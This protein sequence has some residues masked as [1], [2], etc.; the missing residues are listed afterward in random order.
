M[1]LEQPVIRISVRN[2]VEFI[3]RA[4]DIDNRIASTDKDTMQLG[5]RI[6]RKIQKRKGSN[7]HAEVPLKIAIEEDKYQLVIEGRAD[8]IL[9][10]SATEEITFAD[11]FNHRT[12]PIDCKVTID[13][14]KGMYMKLDL[15]EDAI[16]VHRAQAMCYAYI[17]ALQHDLS[18]ISVQMTYCNLDTEDI[19][20]FHYD[21]TFEE[22]ADWFEKLIDEY[23]KWADF[24]FA[25]KKL[26]QASIKPLQFPFPY[27]DGQRELVAG[28]YR[29]IKRKKNL[30]IQAPTGAG[31]T[32]S[33]VFP[34][35]K[36]VG[37]DLADKIFYLTAKTITGT[38]AREAFELLRK[39][40]YQAK[41]LTITAKEKLCLCEEME[42]NPINCPYAKGHYDRVN[43]AVFS[44]LQK[45]D[46]I[47]RE[48]ILE[49]AKEYNVCPFEM[50]L[51]TATWVDDIICDY[52][53]V[54]DPNVYLKR[55][56]GEGTSGE[57]IFL[58]DEAHNLVDRGREMYS[59]HVD[60]ADV[61]EAKRLAGDYSKGLVRALEKVNRQLRTLEKECTE[62]EILPNPG[63]VSLGMLQVMGE[64]D[65]LLEELHGKELPEQLLE[66]Y[67]C[68]RDFL[69]I[70]E[71][72]DENYVVYTEMG[73]GGKVILRLFCVNPAANIH[74]CLE[75]GKSAV[76][77]SAT[78]LP[79]DYYRALL[80]TRKD[81]YGIYVTSPFRQENRCIL[82]GRDVSSRYTRRGYEEYHRIASY[83][84]RTVWTRKGN[85][86]VFFPSY[87]FME[88]VLEVYENEFSAEWV[89]CISQTSGMNEREKEEFL[90][91]FSAS[92][93]TL[94]GFCVMG[95]IFSEGIDLM[96]EKLIGAIIIGTGLPQIGTEREILRQY[97]DKKGV[98]GFDYA[99]RYPGMNK[100]LQSAG[101][102]IRTQ[103]DTGIILLLDERFAGKDYRN[104][105]PAEWSDR[106]NCT[107][108]TVEEQ[109]GSFWNR[110][111][112]K[113]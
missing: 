38:V 62:Y 26:R 60:R 71:L 44:L 59:A 43:D 7:Y 82:T 29:T 94:V 46:V 39:N 61:L 57:Y 53:Y 88:D 97:Y 15:L 110:I 81:D 19:R 104:L 52:N 9:I 12:M 103:E 41:V 83:I 107:L 8:G 50:C 69:N 101:R 47:T 21:Y 106:G 4:G 95:G 72:L 96:G 6:H 40:G 91:E 55:F 76:F 42:C 30:F 56:F 70:D 90:E 32:I 102:V 79:M 11:N 87:K 34:A 93:G 31:K 64:M 18:A 13:E 49:Q 108:N 75:K 58:I 89:R 86:M 74:R 78:L 10:E 5:S 80:S 85:Y 24:Q 111:R 37:E 113:N 65:K 3:L 1:D 27:R 105:F 35:V 2:L 51:D 92:E 84:A 66:F 67:F 17:Y 45:E 14:I 68:V 16:G 25:W 112:E 54:F 23:K 77:F 20:Y 100:V 63:A 109:L 28:V 22:L 98:N 36:A 48:V 99:Y 73:E 33:T